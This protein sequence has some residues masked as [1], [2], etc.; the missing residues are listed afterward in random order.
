M[1]KEGIE[2]FART[3]CPDCSGTGVKQGT[4][5]PT[6]EGSGKRTRWM[7]LSELL[8]IPVAK[9]LTEARRRSGS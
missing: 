7:P 8:R 2:I 5:C 6:C 9:L 1:A 4:A 3:P